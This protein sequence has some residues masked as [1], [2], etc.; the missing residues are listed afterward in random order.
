LQSLVSAVINAAM[1]WRVERAGT[2]VQVR[3]EVP[4]DDWEDLYDAI[5]TEMAEKTSEIAIP[6]ELPRARMIDSNM[7]E[8][9]RQ[10]LADTG[11]PLA[12]PSHPH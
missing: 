8:M 1:P 10:V 6:V 5:K 2:V 12:P 7:L 9:L 4:V 11:I 3:I